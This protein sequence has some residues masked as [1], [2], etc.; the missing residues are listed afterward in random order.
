MGVGAAASMYPPMPMHFRRRDLSLSDTALSL[1]E[2]FVA[3]VCCLLPRLGQVA[4]VYRDYI[5]AFNN[6]ADAAAI[7]LTRK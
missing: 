2:R 4:G 1:F 3:A 5:I 6:T 7:D